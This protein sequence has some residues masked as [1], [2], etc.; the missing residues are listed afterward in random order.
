MTPPIKNAPKPALPIVALLCFAVLAILL[1][2]KTEDMTIIVTVLLSGAFL[3]FVMLTIFGWMLSL[4]NSQ[5]TQE[6][7]RKSIR[8][9][10]NRGF[11]LLLPFTVLAVI[12]TM[13]LGWNAVT[14]FASAGIMTSST[15]IGVELTRLGGGTVRST[16]LPAIGGIIMTTIWMLVL[17][18]L[19]AGMI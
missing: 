10:V 13:G 2:I 6:Y 3:G 15:A 4:F 19:V 17:S 16:L 7:S 9:I 1:V 18:G 14:A 11:L 12:A 8:W 5:I